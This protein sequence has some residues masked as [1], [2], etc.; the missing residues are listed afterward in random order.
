M[1]GMP[2]L[3]AFPT[4]VVNEVELMTV[5]AM[6]A[7][8]AEIAVWMALTIVETAE[9]VDPVHFGVG[10]PNS[11]AASANPYWV[12]PKKLFVV[13]WLTNQNCHFG[14][15]GKFPASL[16]AD[17]A[18]DDPQALSSAAAAALALTSPVP[19]SRRRRVGPS[20][21]LMVSIA[22][23]TFGSTFLRIRTSRKIV[24][25]GALPCVA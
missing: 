14:V 9:F 2:A 19:S 23:S 4:G 7:A 22:S 6:P 1:T 21:M 12:G 20:F 3:I 24:R 18:A 13:T 8:F 15:L 5:V 16:A 10:R 17:L 25:A 11:A